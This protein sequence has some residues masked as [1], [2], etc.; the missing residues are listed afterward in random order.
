MNAPELRNVAVTNVLGGFENRRET[1]ET[2][3]YYKAAARTRVRS[4]VLEFLKHK[5]DKVNTMALKH[6]QA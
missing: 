2:G 4:V 5:N 1:R 6:R 3:K